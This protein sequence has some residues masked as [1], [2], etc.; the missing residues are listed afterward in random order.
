VA[1]DELLSH[2]WEN[3]RSANG[4][5]NLASVGV[6]CEHEVDESAT[7]VLKDG[8]YVIGLV[9][10]EDDGAVGL[11]R[12]AE[13]QVGV[14]GGWV[15]DSAEPEAVGFVLDGDV[16]VDKDGDAACGEGLDDEGR[17]DGDVVVAEDSVTKGAG[18]GAEDLGAAMDGVAVD[19]EV[20]GAAGD[21]VS[22]DDD[23]V[24]GECVDGVDDVFEEEGLGELVEVDVADL[25]DSVA[26]EGVR[27]ICDADGKVDGFEVVARDLAGVKSET[28]GGNTRADEKFSAGETRRLV[29][30]KTGHSS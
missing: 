7:R 5:A 18:E 4:E 30:K 24:G 6:A 26:A 8:F 15:I 21:E 11:G 27:K 28:C 13:F 19:D 25:G 12:D 17:T 20:E 1:F 16:L 14:A 10:H 3:E 9:R 23:E 29:A 22:G 2:G